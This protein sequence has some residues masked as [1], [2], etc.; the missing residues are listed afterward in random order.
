MYKSCVS[1]VIYIYKHI[2]DIIKIENVHT[3][4]LNLKEIHIINKI[5]LDS[6]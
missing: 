1:S 6:V 4:F 2:I 3:Y 5:N